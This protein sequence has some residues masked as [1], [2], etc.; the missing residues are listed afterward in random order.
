MSFQNLPREPTAEQKAVLD[1]KDR[2]RVVRACPGAGKTEMFVEAIRRELTRWTD[3]N[4]GIAALSFTNIARQT[5]EARVGSVVCVPH[6]TG[7]LDGFVF[8]FIV[9]PFAHLL[10]LPQGAVRLFPAAL[11]EQLSKPDVQIGANAAARAPLF[12]TYFIG[13]A[14]K[15]PTMR[16]TN[17]FGSDLV[18]QELVASIWAAKR[19]YWQK[20]GIVTHSDCH[21]L[22]ACILKHKTQGARVRDLIARRFPVVFIDELQDTG[23][24]LAR[25]FVNLCGHAGVRALVV[26]DP[27][28][29]IYGFGGASPTIFDDF[30]ALPGAKDFK[31][32]TSQRC[33]KKI[34]AVASALTSDHTAILAKGDA[35]D[36]IA[37]LVVHDLD[38][39]KLSPG[40]A[41]FIKG[42]Q[43]GETFALVARRS[44]VV[45]G[46]RGE[47]Y[48]DEF[49]GKSSS[50][51]QLNLAVEK[52][53]NGAA[54]EAA[55]I[56]DRELCRLVLNDSEA[57]AD[58]LLKREIT[59]TAW[60]AATFGILVELAK[61]VEGE[62]W[63]AWVLRAKAYIQNVAVSLGATPEDLKRLNTYRICNQNGTKV[64]NPLVDVPVMTLWG[65]TETVSTVHQVKG[66][67]FET[68]V[69]FN[70]KPAAKSPCISTEWWK[71]DGDGEERR[72]AFVAVSR[73]K[74][75]LVLCIHKT[76]Y[77]SLKATQPAFLNLFEAPV[78]LP[79]D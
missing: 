15:E 35:T 64:K 30:Q 36:G 38:K 56:V 69:F 12:K 5:I 57:S 26:G 20:T 13:H 21:F 50:G 2:V 18:P 61:R 54:R 34:A 68:V 52:F 43:A 32:S 8:R 14:G 79:N 24:F 77:E 71:A 23:F 33:P 76:S 48:R 19:N 22:A 59:R 62:T 72:I 58:D 51:R 66:A 16:A 44:A 6:Y 47:Q 73:A 39:P 65:A 29:A 27:N 42:L 1:S 7:T 28:Q 67:E 75:N 49:A 37:T 3:P 41:A 4:A 40:Q 17:A 74:Q 9:K 70:A 45:N 46:L 60:R 78:A 25:S 53:L 31:L 63:N 11:A 55:I 10:D